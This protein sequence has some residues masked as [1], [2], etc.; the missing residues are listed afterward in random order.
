MKLGMI[1]PDVLE[2]LR[3]RGVSSARALAMTPEEV[4]H[5]YCEWH[6]LLGWSGRLWSAVTALQREGGE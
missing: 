4:F 2:A 3:E 1:P 5:E 6:G